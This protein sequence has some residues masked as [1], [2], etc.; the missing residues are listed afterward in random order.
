LIRN[1]ACA[2]IIVPWPKSDQREYC[3]WRPT[4]TSTEARVR[5]S[6]TVAAMSLAWEALTKLPRGVAV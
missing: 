2:G 5:W 3:A 6:S 1:W 4:I